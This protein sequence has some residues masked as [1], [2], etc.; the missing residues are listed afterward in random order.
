MRITKITVHARRE[1]AVIHVDEEDEP[2]TELALDLVVRSGLVVGDLLDAGRLE[3]LEAEDQVLLARD[4]SLRLLAHR[5]R[6]EQEVRRRLA[7]RS[8]PDRVVEDTISWL[9]E[10]GYLD[11]RAF[12]ESFVRDRLRFRPR[13]RRALIQ[14]LRRRGVD[15]STAVTAIESVLAGD[16]VDEA[17]LALEAARAWARKNGDL[18]RASGRTA[19]DGHRARRRLYGHLVRRGFDPGAVSTA[20]ATILDEVGS[21]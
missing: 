18:L 13:G 19:E 16:E 10:R 14:E 3:E 1:R 5:A 9:D 4:A 15:E 11:D 21:D 8:I 20:V 12:A 17:V 7:A 6:S 2:R